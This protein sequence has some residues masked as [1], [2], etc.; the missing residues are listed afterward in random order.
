M[1][2]RTTTYLAVLSFAFMAACGSDSTTGPSAN[3]ATVRFI[4][5][6]STDIDVYNGGIIPA[7]NGGLTFNS[8]STCLPVSTTGTGLAFNSTTTSNRVSAPLTF[9]QSFVAGGNYTVVAY[10]NGTSV[11]FATF[12]NGG[13]TPASGQ[14]G[15]RAVNAA[16]NSG[17][18]VMNSNGTAVG[19]GI[20]FATAGDFVN[21][22]ATTQTISFNNGAGTAIL[23]TPGAMSFNAGLKYTIVVGPPAAGTTRL[24]SF[25]ISGC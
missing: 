10:N 15:V 24:R 3:T 4:N 25:L 17:S 11:G 19:G 20:P 6:S 23:D 1:Q 21:M 5:A 7:G 2:F 8:S 13:F 22:T 14:A 18:I 16:P 12:D 9:T